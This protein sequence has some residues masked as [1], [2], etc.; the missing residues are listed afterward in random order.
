VAGGLA[1]DKRRV[2]SGQVA[3]SSAK[4]RAAPGWSRCVVYARYGREPMGWHA[5]I[6][7]GVP[8]FVNPVK[9]LNTLAKVLAEEQVLR[10]R[11]KAGGFAAKHGLK[12]IRLV[13]T[14]LPLAGKPD[15]KAMSRRIP[16][17]SG[18]YKAQSPGKSA[19]HNEAPDSRDRVNAAAV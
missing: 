12:F 6:G 15:C 17:I 1:A 11:P 4:R 5:H 2:Q 10:S 16:L 19:Q 7:Q 18:T 8:L 3:C 13:W 14:C 9:A